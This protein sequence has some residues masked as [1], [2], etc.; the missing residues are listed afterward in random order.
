MAN[1]TP[2]TV[3]KKQDYIIDILSDDMG[4][5]QVANGVLAA[6]IQKNVLEIDGVMRLAPQGIMEGL[7]SIFS[8]RGYDSNISIETSE[9][10]ATISLALNLRF[11]CEIPAVAANVQKKLFEVIPQLTGY[12]VSKVN[13]MVAAIEDEIPAEETETAVP[14][15]TI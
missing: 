15:Q 13:I 9:E 10:G 6:I 4:K 3:E 5:V 12:K 2:Q 11:G 14:V 1:E 8:R 7:T